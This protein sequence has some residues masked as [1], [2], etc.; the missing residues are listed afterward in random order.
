MLEGIKGFIL[1]AWGR[2]MTT[3]GNPVALET[4]ASP[5]EGPC[6]GPGHAVVAAGPAFSGRQRVRSMDAS[7]VKG[8]HVSTCASLMVLSYPELEVLQ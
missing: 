4:G 2:T 1:G 7:F 6:C 8:D 3:R 5:A